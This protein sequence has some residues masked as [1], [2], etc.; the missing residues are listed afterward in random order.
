MGGLYNGLQRVA[1]TALLAIAV[2]QVT[3]GL[4]IY[5]PVQ[6]W[7]LTRL[8]G[9]DDPARTIHFFSLL[10]LAF[11]TPGHGIMGGLLPRTLPP[12]VTRRENGTDGKAE[13]S[14]AHPPCSPHP[15]C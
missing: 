1:Y 10:G 8:F 12:M 7:P 13:A 4:A 15:R 2:I 11:F 14:Q 5:K 6:L 9:G 3:T